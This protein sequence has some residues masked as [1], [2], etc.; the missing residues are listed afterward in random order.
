MKNDRY[1][2]KKSDSRRG[3][4]LNHRRMNGAA[5][6]AMILFAAFLMTALPGCSTKGTATDNEQEK[7]DETSE[8]SSKEPTATAMP[9]PTESATAEPTEEPSS[10]PTATPLPDGWFIDPRGIIPTSV[11]IV[12]PEL[13]VMN[14]PHPL[15]LQQNVSWCITRIDG[16][17]VLQRWTRSGSMK[18]WEVPEEFINMYSIQAS[19]AENSDDVSLFGYRYAHNYDDCLYYTEMQGGYL[20]I[21]SNSQCDVIDGIL[22]ATNDGRAIWYLWE[23]N[24]YKVHDFGDALVSVDSD[25]FI[26]VNRNGSEEWYQLNTTTWE[27]RDFETK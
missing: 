19:A 25:A 21:D 27:E 6:L 23:E 17:A 3:A 5:L 24:K 13:A 9:K 7:T 1:S 18:Q 8:E 10:V 12:V 4:A 22:F 2:A 26:I 20:F 16:K 15:V 11:E 14:N